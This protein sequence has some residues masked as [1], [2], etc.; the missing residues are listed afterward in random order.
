MLDY[1]HKNTF[2]HKKVTQTRYIREMVHQ[3][4]KNKYFPF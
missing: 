4:M 3:N 2:F 1:E